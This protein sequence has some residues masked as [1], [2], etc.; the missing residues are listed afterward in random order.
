MCRKDIAAQI[1]TMGCYPVIRVKFYH[2]YYQGGTR[3][4]FKSSTE[5]K[6]SMFFLTHEAK[7]FSLGRVR[8]EQ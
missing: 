1:H 7:E 8:K 2:L 6:Y 3:W 4:H 5:D